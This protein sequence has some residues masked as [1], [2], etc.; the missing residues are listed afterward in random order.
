MLTFELRPLLAATLLAEVLFV[1]V[2][3]LVGF[4]AFKMARRHH[5]WIASIAA[6]VAFVLSMKVGGLLF[7]L[8]VAV[9]VT[10]LYYI[11]FSLRNRQQK[12]ARILHTVIG[13]M[14]IIWAITQIVHLPVRVAQNQEVARIAGNIAG[15]G[16]AFA[17][18][19]AF[20]E[21]LIRI[22]PIEGSVR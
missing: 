7:T 20:V 9:I 4:P 11:L 3:I 21:S 5:C 19:S 17:L 22:R 14:L 16:A 12:W 18:S 6:P 10:V 1:I 15:I 13:V 2:G 8:P